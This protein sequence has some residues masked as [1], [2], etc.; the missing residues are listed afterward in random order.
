LNLPTFTLPAAVDG[1]WTDGVVFD[2]AILLR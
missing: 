1:H 2:G